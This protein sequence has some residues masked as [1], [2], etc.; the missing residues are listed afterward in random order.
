VTHFA[1]P[2]GEFLPLEAEPVPMPDDML[3]ATG[4]E[5]LGMSLIGRDLS[6]TIVIFALA[7]G[8]DVGRWWNR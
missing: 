1:I 5:P 7:T 2:D 8:V 4:I 3:L 6:F